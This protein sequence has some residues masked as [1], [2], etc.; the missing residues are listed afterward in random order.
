VSGTSF[1]RVFLALASLLTLGAYFDA[2]ARV[3]RSNPLAPWDEVGAMA[4][5]LAITALVVV[6][7]ARNLARGAPWQRALPDGYQLSL[8]GC[9]LFGVAAV[10]D[11]YWTLAFGFG[12]GLQALTSPLHLIELVA[13][14]AIVSGPLR[15]AIRG[16]EEVAGVPALVSAALTLSAVTFV[17]QFANPF[18]DLWS[19]RGDHAP[20]VTWW[21]AESTGITAILLQVLILLSFV[22]LL[23]RRFTVRPGS[24]TLVC[25][26]NGAIVV[27]VKMNL[28]LLPAMVATGLVADGLVVALRPTASPD[29]ARR[30]SAVSA[31]LS[32]AYVVS[33]GLSV[34]IAYGTWWPLG[35][36]AGV[37]LI[38]ALLGFLL[39][40]LLGVRR[41]PTPVGPGD[42]WPRHHEVE[43]SPQDV[44]QALEVLR[45]PA[46]LA[47]SPMARLACISGEGDAAGRELHDLLV[48]V[49]R[50][51]ATSEAPRD[52]E[53]GQLLAE[54]YLRRAG[55]HEVIA[56]RLHLSRPTFYRR[57]Q[58]GLGLVAERIDELSEFAATMPRDG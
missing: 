24:L 42:R 1:E 7:L 4:G 56:E 38:A 36:W 41:L 27:L 21:V 29:S 58:R 40:Q 26:L 54:Y 34:A 45:D 31:G 10:V 32:A 20:A 6:T 11:V 51:L 50:E 18:I 25:T 17:T 8:L 23:V 55:S 49:V 14:V 43:V 15:A 35:L 13:G 2:W 30:L 48:D 39:A 46:A 28:P 9:L 5:W 12:S 33:Y 52:A 22:L 16:A 19:A 47:A 37:A 3:Q 53:A 44:K 57:L